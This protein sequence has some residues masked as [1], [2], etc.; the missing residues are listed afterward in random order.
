LVF[1]L[2]GEDPIPSETSLDESIVILAIII[3]GGIAA[4]LF[5]LKGYKK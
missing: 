3:I 4:A 2:E 5:F 1:S